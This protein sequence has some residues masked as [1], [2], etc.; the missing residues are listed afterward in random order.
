MANLLIA[1]PCVCSETFVRRCAFTWLLVG[2]IGG[3]DEPIRSMDCRDKHRAERIDRPILLGNYMEEAQIFKSHD[4]FMIVESIAIRIFSRVCG[5]QMVKEKLWGDL[6][7]MWSDKDN[8][9][10]GPKCRS[11]I[12]KMGLYPARFI[13]DYNIGRAPSLNK[14]SSKYPIHSICCQLHGPGPYT[15]YVVERMGQARVNWPLA[16]WFRT[17][18]LKGST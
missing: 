13:V 5:S 9:V 8:L 14:L 10:S 4:Q 16:E 11:P 17:C 1:A 15:R 6:T 18:L 3:A 2:C 7:V 12:E